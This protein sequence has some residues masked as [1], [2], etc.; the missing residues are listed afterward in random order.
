MTVINPSRTVFYAIEKAIKTYRQY[1]QRQISGQGIDITVD[2]LLVLRAIQDHPGIAQNQ[3]AEMVFKDYA[4]V[5]RM[6]DLLVKKKYLQRKIHSQDRRRFELTITRE[7]SQILNQ[8]DEVV[9]NYRQQALQ[10]ISARDEEILHQL[11]GKIT[12]N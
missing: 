9:A 3:I 5:T 12:D 1:A 2:Q 10:G 7:G 6:I 11:L 4:S 8:L